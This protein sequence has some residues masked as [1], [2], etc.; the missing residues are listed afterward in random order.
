MTTI[1]TGRR[2]SAMGFLAIV[3]LVGTGAAFARRMDI[4]AAVDGQEP[5]RSPGRPD[6]RDSVAGRWE[7]RAELP[8][9]NSEMSVAAI[10][11]RI[12]VV[13]GYPSSRVSVSTV[14]V[15][16]PLTDR[17]ELTT[18]L[19][20][21]LNHTV[22]ASVDGL[23]YVIGGQP[24]AGGAGPFVNTVYAFDPRS[25]T[26]SMRQ[27]M[28]T[29]RGGGGAAVV[30]GLIYVAGGRPPRG[31]DFAAYNPRTDR[32]Q[33]LPTMPT[34]RNHIGMVAVGSDIYVLGG[35][36]GAG[37][38]SEQ[39][40]TV[41][42]FDTRARRWRTGTSLPMARGG[43]NAVEAY[44][45]IHVF[46]GEGSDHTDSGVHPD[47]DVYDP[48]MDRWYSL[49]PMPVPVH[50]VTGAAFVDRWIHLPGG[51]VSSGGASG[52]TLHQAY[53]PGLRCPARRMP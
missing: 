41:E 20:R 28:P 21:A 26:W 49:P 40:A 45:C 8:E 37:F 14:Q 18:P 17:W 23:L 22:A 24:E 16:D 30:D 33:E 2:V 19:P 32:W 9:P 4:H 1:G 51:G 47:H 34:Q 27:P 42:V 3:L 38:E 15:Y 6:L 10:D 13:A 46:G 7:R 44:G 52:S 50:G 48:F 5:R 25:A 43:I 12:F 11:G 31:Q 53:R 29:A 39:T 35:R 36:F